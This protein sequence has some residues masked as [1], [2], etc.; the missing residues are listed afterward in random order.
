MP[1]CV[2]ENSATDTQQLLKNFQIISKFTTSAEAQ[3]LADSLIKNGQNIT[4]IPDKIEIS[5]K[6]LSVGLYPNKTEA[7]TE[8]NNLQKNHIAAYAVLQ[9]GGSY[10]V[11]AGALKDENDYWQHYEKLLGLGYHRIHTQLIPSKTTVYYVVRPKSE[12]LP[13]P[14]PFITPSDSKGFFSDDWR[15]EVTEGRFKGEYSLWGSGQDSGSANYFKSTIE[16]RAYYKRNLDL[17]AG[18]RFEAFEQ[19]ATY[20]YQYVQLLPHPIYLRY[21][22]PNLVWTIGAI[23][24]V[25]D[26]RNRDSL[27]NR[28]DSKN[29]TRYRLDSDQTELEQPVLALRWEY[30]KSDHK[31]DAIITPFYQ[32]SKLPR[33]GSVWHPIN[34]QEGKILGIKADTTYSNLIKNGRF[35]NQKVLSGGFGV[36]ILKQV[37]HRSIKPPIT[38]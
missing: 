17:N 20:N 5:L 35:G 14:I 23:N 38:S 27:S 15:T 13:L 31:F 19:S 1:I 8:V 33:F 30:E 16:A 22:Q 24:A 6:T 34:P 29:L 2:A 28:L 26:D 25:W 12:I 3:K 9:K 11:Y 7:D 21:R 36:R 18:F 32:P 10:R 4:I 37:G